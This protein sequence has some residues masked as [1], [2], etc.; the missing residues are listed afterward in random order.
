MDEKKIPYI[1]GP[2]KFDHSKNKV[3][4]KTSRRKKNK[5]TGRDSSMIESKWVSEDKQGNRFKHKKWSVGDGW[6]DYRK[7]KAVRRGQFDGEIAGDHPRNVGPE[8]H[9]NY[10]DIKGFNEGEKTAQG[11]PVPK[12]T[13]KVYK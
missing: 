6:S 11:L 9:K 8:F 13:I 1:K 7:A 5:A 4:T 2:A 10:K 12:K 3:L